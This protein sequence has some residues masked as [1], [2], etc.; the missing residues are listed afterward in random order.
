[1]HDRQTGTTTRVSLATGAVQANND[2]F[3]PTISEDGRFVAFESEATNLVA[4]DTNGFDDVFHHDRQ[5]G[6][7]TRIS[8][9]TTGTLQSNED[10]FE[11]AIS[12]DGRFV[13]F[14]SFASNLVPGDTNGEGDVFL[15]DTQATITTRMSVG[16]SGEQGNDFSCNPA[17]SHDGRVVGFFSDSTN[18]VPGGSNGLR[19]IFVRDSWQIAGI[20]DL[21]ANPTADLLWRN[22]TTGTVSAWFMN[23][24]TVSSSAV[25]ANITPD[26][27]IGGVGDLDGNGTA[28][29]VW[30]HPTTGIVAAWYMTPVTGAIERGE[31]LATGLPAEWII[32]GIGD[33]DGNGTADVVWRHVPSGLV[34][35]WYMTPGTGAVGPSLVL[36]TITPD[37]VIGGVGDID[38]N[39][40]ADVVWRHPTTGTVAA[41]LMTPGTGAV[42]PKIVLATG[43]PASWIIGGIGDLD[44]NGTA[45]VVW[46]HVPSGLV[47]GWLMTLGTGL[48]GTQGV[49]STIPTDWNI[50]GMGDLNNN[51]RADV[52]WHRPISGTTA[53]W[54]MN[55]LT[56]DDSGLITE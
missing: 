27:V 34:A 18:L 43:L 28:D 23:G 38:G 21:N 2:S 44:N 4:G 17:I 22:T 37:W 45:D 54:L 56:L 5:T 32:T 3:L 12:G 55:G 53:G 24:L 47:A 36:D 26:W 11:A 48:V 6:T 39:G 7:T 10:S 52:V 33:L 35:A 20:G 29:V 1:M 41:W 8:V 9:R 49:I 19:H 13:A 31:V 42:G 40:T 50:A 14:L 46:R 25:L 30:R 51:G 15:H 16:A